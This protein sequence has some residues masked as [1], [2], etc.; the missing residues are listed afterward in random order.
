MPP[1]N[2]FNFAFSIMSVI[3]PIMLIAFLGIFAFVIISAIRQWNKNNNS[4]ILTVEAKVTSKRA[5]ISHSNNAM[6]HDNPAMGHSSS[7]TSYYA[8]F[9]VASGDRFELHLTPNEYAMLAEGDKGRLTFQGSRY[10][11]FARSIG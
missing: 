11:G 5:N 8:T 6:H 2:S 10:K 1:F 7:S 9:E 3:F 4:P